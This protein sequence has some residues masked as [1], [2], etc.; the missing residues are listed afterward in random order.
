MHVGI[1]GMLLWYYEHLFASM[2]YSVKAGA[3]GR[4]VGRRA[5]HTK[6]GRNNEQ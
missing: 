5:S 1:A 3:R 4:I 6:E 2:H